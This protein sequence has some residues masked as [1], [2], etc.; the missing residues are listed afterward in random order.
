M[1]AESRRVHSMKNASF[2]SLLP[3]LLV[4]V[5]FIPSTLYA[6]PT[7]KV[8]VYNNKPI[9]FV[10]E[11]GAVQ[12]LFIDI[13]EDV[14]LQEDWEIEYVIGHFSEV[15]DSLKAGTID[16]LP[17]TAFS[18]EREAVVNFTNET[19]LANWGEIYTSTLLHI[20]SLVE[21]E[22]KIIA[23]KQGDIH[24][25]ALQNLVENFNISCRFIET[26]E[27][28]TIFEM[29]NSHYVDIGVVNRLYGNDNKAGYNVRDTPIIFN[30]IDLRY[31]FPKNKN[32]NIAN[33]L[34]VYLRSA[35]IN[36]DSVYYQ[37]IN[38]WLVFDTKTKLPRWVW[39]LITGVIGSTLFFL[40][41]TLLFRSE[42]KK[43]TKELSATN[44]QLN[45]QIEE[46]KK[47]E[48]ELRKF[49]H[50]VE[51]SCDAMALVD[52]E[53]HHI[54]ANSVYR[55]EIATDKDI[56]GVAIQDLLGRDFFDNE[57]KE[58]VLA[59]LQGR[60]VH[61]QTMLRKEKGNIS[62]W[63]ITLS[64]YY[65]NNDEIAGY[66]IDIRDVTGQ[67]EIQNRLENAQKM[68]AI[69]LLAG[70]VAHDLNNILSGLV[71]YPDMLL[72]GRAADDPMTKPLQT[73]KKSGERAAA[74]VQDLLTLARRNIGAETVVNL[75]DIV[76][77]FVASPEHD[78]IVKHVAA[79]NVALKLDKDLFNIR[80]S[81][82]HLQKILMNL[83]CN[84]LEA[85]PEGG[86]LALTTENRSFDKEYIGYEYIPAGEYA[87]L[88]IEDSG[89]G[90][91]FLEIK[92]IFEP[93]Y[94]NKI[95]GRSGTGLGMAVVWGAI[96]DHKGFIDI[97]S[98]P[99]KGTLF[100]MYFP[101]SRETLPEKTETVLQN[102]MGKGE[103]ILVVD[104]MEE[105]RILAVQ[106]L[107]LLGY[108]VDVASSGEEA[109]QKCRESTFDLIILD[110][111][112]PG[113]MDGYATYER[114][115]TFKEVQKA[116]IVSGFSDSRNV[117]KA[118]ESG[119]GTYLKKPY[120]ITSLAQAVSQELAADVGRNTNLPP[121]TD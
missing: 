77:E 47:T 87:V 2:L 81:A 119:A 49:A 27:Y 106:I 4:L 1:P 114:I 30:P 113:G 68:E 88:S 5:L 13:L 37:A 53:H 86:N 100:T 84:A 8:G 50:I 78:N 71:S 75:N 108:V 121:D 72:V 89:V 15:F 35:K 20:T 96:K 31:A 3:A 83:F 65:L 59:C 94:T 32:E 64:P 45:A 95:L 105:Q 34:D 55:S 74:I 109:V 39:Q 80:G 26:D 6:K 17:A 97:L 56:T 21:L 110:M 54:L 103:K 10:D 46:R 66:V 117:Q 101:I 14:A 82:V 38:R 25:K 24:F 112:M 85:M 70:G 76:K 73:I 28:E 61:V 116:I 92:R 44:R 111:I 42:V 48:E 63:S 107:H 104:D 7:L 41:A 60:V 115:K 22:G 58:S 19:V 67:V 16:I 36:Q 51:A 12:G 40:A 29:L 52:T 91:S 118:Q 11:A 99:G 102:F 57:L 120:T 79:M 9:I 33:T 69:G 93:F 98:E 43:R 62:F 90:M 18:R 23:V